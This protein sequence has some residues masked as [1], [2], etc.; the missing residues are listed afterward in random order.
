MMAQR[1]RQK[2]PAGVR[3]VPGVGDTETNE[4]LSIAVA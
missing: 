1:A 4:A 2:K 3:F